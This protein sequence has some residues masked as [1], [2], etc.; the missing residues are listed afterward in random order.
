MS[1][2]IAFLSECEWD[3]HPTRHYI[4][5]K[6]IFDFIRHESFIKKSPAQI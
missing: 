3:Q 6:T 5:Q 4:L 1:G 2:G